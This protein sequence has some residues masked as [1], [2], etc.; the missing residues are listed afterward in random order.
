M[1]KISGFILVC[2]L[3]ISFLSCDRMLPVDYDRAFRD[4]MVITTGE[5][6]TSSDILFGMTSR[7]FFTLMRMDNSGEAIIQMLEMD[8]FRE[9]ARANGVDMANLR[10]AL[11]R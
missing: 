10:R 8:M 9:R 2:F 5:S 11:R 6:I 3:S 1:K 4:Y 7:D